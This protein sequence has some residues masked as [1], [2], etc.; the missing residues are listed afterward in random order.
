M[1]HTDSVQPFKTCLVGGL[2][3]LIFPYSGKNRPNWLLYFPERFCQPPT[4]YCYWVYPLISQFYPLLTTIS[5][6]RPYINHVN[7]GIINHINH[8]LTI[9]T[10][11][12][13]HILTI[14]YHQ[15]VIDVRWISISDS[16][17]P[18][19]LRNDPPRSSFIP[20]TLPGPRLGMAW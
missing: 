15:A 2:E 13:N 8:I 18:W 6:Y 12:I 14:Y 20:A 17:P 7:N 11:I 5:I 10:I 19:T 3:H 4:R 9:L 1:F 16:N